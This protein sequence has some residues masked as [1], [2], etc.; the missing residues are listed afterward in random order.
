MNDKLESTELPEIIWTLPVEKV[1]NDMGKD[2]YII[3]I[4]EKMI[5][6]MKLKT[7]D[8]LFWGE[9]SN[10]R[11]EVRKAKKDELQKFKIDLGHDSA[12][13]QARQDKFVL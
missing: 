7:G 1:K 5:R 2:E 8:K 13:Q 4:P 10:N 12:L 6:H 9:R 11:Y 3:S